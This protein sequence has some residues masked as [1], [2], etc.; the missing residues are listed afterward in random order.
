MSLIPYNVTSFYQNNVRIILYQVRA[1]IPSRVLMPLRSTF[2][3]LPVSPT[4]V[5]LPQSFR[6]FSLML[7]SHA[8]VSDVRAPAE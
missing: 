4:R 6:S 5:N 1:A 8:T 2:E 3:S 7:E